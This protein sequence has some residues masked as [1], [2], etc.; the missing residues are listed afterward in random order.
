MS[1]KETAIRMDGQSIILR[2]GDSFD[3]LKGMV[4]SSV[5]GVVTDPPYG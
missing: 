2:F 1:N 3:I 4:K 5:A